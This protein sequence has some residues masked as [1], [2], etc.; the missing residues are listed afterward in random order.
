[1]IPNYCPR[2]GHSDTWQRDSQSDIKGAISGKVIEYAYKC[3]VCGNHTVTPA[4]VPVK[5]VK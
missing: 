3:S 4:N 1:M 2:C 5:A